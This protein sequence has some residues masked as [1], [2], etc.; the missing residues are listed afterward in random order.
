MR[1]SNEEIEILKKALKELDENAEIY[2]FG[3][4]VNDN[5][6]GGDIDILIISKKLNKKL[7]RPLRDKFFEKFGEQKI[8]I[9][10]DNGEL[11]DPFVKKIYKEAVSFM[12]NSVLQN[13]IDALK[14][15]LSW[16]KRSFEICKNHDTNIDYSNDDFDSFETLAGRFSRSINFLVR[17]AFRSFDDYEFEGQGTLIDTVNNAHKRGLF[18]NIED[19]KR[20][21]DLRNEIVHEYLDESLS[22]NFTELIELTPKLIEIIENTIEYFK[23]Y[24]KS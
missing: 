10:I 24:S 7:V 6:R 17:K 9:I 15:Q 1:L 14:K 8:D 19:M 18:Q 5:E 23:K 3:S 2:L 4:R 21:R 11:N 16:L 22:D 20:I 13:N 12:S